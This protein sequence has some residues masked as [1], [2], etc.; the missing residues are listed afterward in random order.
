MWKTSRELFFHTERK[1]E[2]SITVSSSLSIEKDIIC[3]KLQINIFNIHSQQTWLNFKT[4][5]WPF[6]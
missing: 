6:Q 1:I 4:E 3:E 5:T 2:I